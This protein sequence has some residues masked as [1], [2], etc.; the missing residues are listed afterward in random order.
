M[1]KSIGKISKELDIHSQTLRDLEKAGKITSY[2]TTG[3]HRR[4]DINEIKQQLL[5]C[6]PYV[7]NEKNKKVKNFIVKMRKLT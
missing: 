6:N 3:G 2:K 5:N 4:Y 7:K 1:L